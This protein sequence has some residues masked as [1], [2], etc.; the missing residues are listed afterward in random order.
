M[1][2]HVVDNGS[3]DGT[4]EEVAARFPKATLTRLGR[5]LGFAEGNNVGIR[6]A[7]RGEADYVGL[8]NQDT[9]VE[10]GWLAPLID[11][12]E[13]DPGIGIL[14]PAQ[15]T[16]DGDACDPNF[17]T[18]LRG[19]P[20][21]PVVDVPTAP[22]AALLVRRR[23]FEEIGL[24][25]P[26]YFAYFEEADFCRRAR[27]RGFRTVVVPAGRIHH[28][29]GLLHPQEMPLRIQLLSLRNQFVFA[30]KDPEASTAANL[31]QCLVLW[32]REV[33]Y[34][35]KHPSGWQKGGAR[36]LAL[37]WISLWLVVSVPRV[38]HHVRLERRTAAYL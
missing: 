16:Y 13:S 5:N 29:H 18:I 24:F 4:A 20:R 6:A 11:V 31:R 19:R 9:W 23:V 21:G 28:R 15:L 17:E 32:G 26:L 7:L 37:A 1:A 10:P 38:L 27:F 33:R 22:G 34:C 25:D 14:S 35:F 36:A 3:T 2:V 8:L 12:A 30:L